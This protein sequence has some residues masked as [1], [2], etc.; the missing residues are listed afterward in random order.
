MYYY[1]LL[2]TFLMAMLPVGELRLSIPMAIHQLQVD[3]YNAWLFSILGN[4]FITLILIGIIYYY[5]INRLKY[6]LGKIPF[7]GFVFRKWENSTIK[8]SEKIQKWGYLGLLYFVSLPLPVTGAWT[9]VLIAFF[10]DLKPFKTFFSITCGLMVS[11]TIVTI[12]SLYLPHF[13]GYN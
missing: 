3:W 12:I 7:V 5:G 13:F 2:T 4:S 11:A 8:K 1:N 10:L 6:F 9:A